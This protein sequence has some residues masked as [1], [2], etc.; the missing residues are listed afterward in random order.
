MGLERLRRTVPKDGRVPHAVPKD[1]VGDGQEST[2][3]PQAV[4]DLRV[5]SVPQPSLR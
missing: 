4:G 2:A 1:G 5:E 3:T